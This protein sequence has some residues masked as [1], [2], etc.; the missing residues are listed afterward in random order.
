M[1]LT[2]YLDK[3]NSFARA[4]TTAERKAI[5]VYD[6]TKGWTSRYAHLDVPEELVNAILTGPKKRKVLKKIARTLL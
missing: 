1:K 2:E 6:Y 3:R 5:G 4:L